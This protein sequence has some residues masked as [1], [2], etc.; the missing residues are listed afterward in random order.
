MGVIGI[1]TGV[2]GRT[3]GIGVSG[4]AARGG[5]SIEPLE[6]SNATLALRASCHYSLSFCLKV[7]HQTWEGISSGLEG[8]RLTTFVPW[9]SIG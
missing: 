8:S 4:A 3:A 7:F 5:A 2:G 1:R 9:A 6:A